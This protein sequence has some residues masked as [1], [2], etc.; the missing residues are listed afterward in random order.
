MISEYLSK[1]QEISDRFVFKFIEFSNK[2]IPS[3]ELCNFIKESI[4][5]AYLD[6]DLS[7]DFLITKSLDGIKG[8]IKRTVIPDAKTQ[9]EK[10]VREGDLGEVIAAL[11]V[12]EIQG[13]VHLNK[14]RFKFNKNKS[15]FGTD[16]VALNSLDDTTTVYYYEVKTLYDGFTKKDN[17]YIT[18]IAYEALD[19]DF[20][21]KTNTVLDF[22]VKILKERG[23]LEHASKLFDLVF[24]PDS[25]NP[26]FGIFIITDKNLTQEDLN[27][28]LQQLNDLP[29]TLSPLSV[30]FVF[31][32]NLKRFVD[33]VWSNIEEYGVNLIKGNKE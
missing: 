3:I 12:S 32:D 21:A 28:A 8:Y 19:K 14:L 25:I 29:P 20:S 18:V 11:I 24:E 22:W 16:I 15:V 17:K 30:T 31:L 26:D 23:D 7:K 27:C 5:K 10:N 9:L 1:K 6:Q 2:A 13:K 33:D 4:L